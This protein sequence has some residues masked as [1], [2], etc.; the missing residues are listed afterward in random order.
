MKKPT[1]ADVAEKAG[2]S[3]PTVSRFLKNENVKPQIAE[4]IQ[5]AIDELGYVPKNSGKADIQLELEE[6]KEFIK[7]EPAKKEEKKIVKTKARKNAKEKKGYKFAL[8]T[9]HLTDYRTR[10]ML[11]HLQKTLVEFG[12]TLQIVSTE[13]KEELEEQYL[14]M[15]IVQNVN[16]ILIES[17]SSAEFIMKQLRTTA[18]P[19]I[20]LRSHI[21]GN[22][23][24]MDE[25]L[26]ANI[27]A[28]Y[29]MEK[30]H[31]IIRYLG[32]DEELTR[33]HLEG[34]RNAYHALKQPIDI[35]SVHS[36]GEYEDL[37][38]K[39]KDMFAEQI[40]LLIL[41]SDEMAVPVSKYLKEYHIAVPQNVSMV[42]FGGT[43]LTNVMS[44]SLTCLKYDYAGY[45]EYVCQHVFAMI[46]KKA[47]PDK[48]PFFIVEEKDSVR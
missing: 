38:Q 2:V 28:K 8:L 42:S 25:V 34:I 43:A 3:K 9:N 15:F 44:P 31:L 23:T 48:K 37:F 32:T 27:L 40:D 26:A 22:D 35:V 30:Q 45:G 33:D 41:Q 20:F 1:I 29:L 36:D 21:E 18:I 7:K 19:Y 17:C 24:A 11:E 4:K 14:T 12:C 47:L 16:A 6:G 39:I 10:M 46:E 13:G 5:A